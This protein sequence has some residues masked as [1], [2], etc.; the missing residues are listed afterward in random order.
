MKFFLANI[1]RMTKMSFVAGA[2]YTKEHKAL[3]SCFLNT[4]RCV[5]CQQYRKQETRAFLFPAVTLTLEKSLNGLQ[6][7]K[8]RL[9]GNHLTASLSELSARYH[10]KPLGKSGTTLRA[11]E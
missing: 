9:V 7:R 5:L 11:N 2:M 4:E 1:E 3:A 6:G 8:H 10:K